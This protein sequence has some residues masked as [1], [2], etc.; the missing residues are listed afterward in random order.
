MTQR[1]PARE[2]MAMATTLRSLALLLVLS[3]LLAACSALDPFEHGDPLAEGEKSL[4]AEKDGK[5]GSNVEYN[6]YDPAIAAQL[7]GS[8]T[9]AAAAAS[10]AS[11][12]T[13]VAEKASLAK[14]QEDDG[15][16]YDPWKSILQEVMDSVV[17]SPGKGGADST[18]VEDRLT[19][20]QQTAGSRRLL[21]A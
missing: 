5:D 15:T 2:R 17:V 19:H 8:G 21:R 9:A 11:G 12:A 7:A 20:A 14:S 6:A 10:G 18:M 3:Q 13:A 1:E 16:D 4:V